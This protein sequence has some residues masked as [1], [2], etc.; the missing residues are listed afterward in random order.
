MN[1]T[2]DTAL[3]GAQQPHGYNITLGPS[4][5]F[6]RTKV[7]LLTCWPSLFCLSDSLQWLGWSAC[8]CSSGSKI[9]NNNI[10]MI[11]IDLLCLVIVRIRAEH[12]FQNELILCDISSNDS[13][14]THLHHGGW[15]NFYDTFLLGEFS[16]DKYFL[17]KTVFF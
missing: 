4:P 16:V 11:F 14:I 1:Q 9:D 15:N 8:V 13:F 2:P 6:L 17:H 3:S 5:A 12:M 7:S 10:R